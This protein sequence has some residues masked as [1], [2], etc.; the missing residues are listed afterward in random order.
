MSAELMQ[1]INEECATT[2]RNDAFGK[3]AMVV[4]EYAFVRIM[5]HVL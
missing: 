5:V 4:L 2:G 1:L 3:R